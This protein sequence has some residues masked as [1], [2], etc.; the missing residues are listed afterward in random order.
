MSSGAMV[1]A[2]V[3]SIAAAAAFAIS[4]VLEQEVASTTPARESLRLR[5]IADLVQRP[6]WVAGLAVSALGFVLQA[7]ALGFGPLTLVEPLIVTELFFAL[8]LAARSG[9][10][11]MGRRELWG[12]TC[13]VAGLT[14]TLVISSPGK[15]RPLPSGRAWIGVGIAVVVVVGLCSLLAGRDNGVR[16]ATLL[17]VCTGVSFGLLSALLKAVT[18]LLAHR[19]VFGALS[20]WEPYSLA[21]VAPAGELFAQ[22]AFQAGPLAA[23]LPAIDALEPAVG[24]AIGAVAFHEPLAHSPIAIVLELVG[25]VLI[26]TGI[27]VVDSSPVMLQLQRDGRPRQ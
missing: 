12:M 8:P 5:L 23:S 1:I 27:I 22:S 2:I 15:G 10:R 6:R 13:V 19:G 9:H 21:V 20:T 3:C 16:R 17:G 24:V 14:L 7:V 25:V 26:I 18:F 11:K 4:S